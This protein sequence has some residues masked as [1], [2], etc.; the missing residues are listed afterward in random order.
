MSL[1]HRF[2]ENTREGTG[3]FA[4]RGVPAPV[5]DAPGIL[6]KYHF[7]VL[8]SPFLAHGGLKK[9]A[10]FRFLEAISSKFT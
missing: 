3:F 2:F 1:H 5:P 7:L 6:K 9:P 8:L 4:A 10:G